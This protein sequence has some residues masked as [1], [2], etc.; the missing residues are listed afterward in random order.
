MIN[1]EVVNGGHRLCTLLLATPE[2]AGRVAEFSSFV[3][4]RQRAANLAA[5]KLEQ[6]SVLVA[7][8]GMA[9]GMDVVCSPQP[10]HNHLQ[11]W[12]MSAF[13]PDISMLSLSC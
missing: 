7:S 9:R 8:D 4:A 2:N 5:F 6:R 13:K 11:L 1:H 12:H 10:L 3:D